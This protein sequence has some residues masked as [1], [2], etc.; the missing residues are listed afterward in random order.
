MCPHNSLQVVHL[1]EFLD[2]VATENEASSSIVHG[3]SFS[4]SRVRIGPNEVA[5]WA[6]LRNVPESI[7]LGDLI[8]KGKGRR[9]PSMNAEYFLVDDGSEGKISKD[10]ND[11]IPN[12]MIPILSKDL[13]IEAISASQR[14]S[15]MISPQKDVGK[16]SQAFERKEVADCL[17]GV[18]ASI[19]VI[20]QEDVVAV[21][22]N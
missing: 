2:D 22:G 21:L 18:I 6:R 16:R 9:K 11:P 7:D 3:P 8:Y 4:V 20:S 1:Q 13:V 12:F 19:D 17:D 15:F 5:H 10:F 14:C